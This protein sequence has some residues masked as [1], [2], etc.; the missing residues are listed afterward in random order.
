MT[1][2]ASGRIRPE[3]GYVARYIPAYRMDI[4]RA[5]ARRLENGLVVASGNPPGGTS[6]ESLMVSEEE[7]SGALSRLDVRNTWIRGEWL[8][9][10]EMGPLFGPNGP[11]R[12][13]L[14]EESPR[15]LSLRRL[16]RSA[17][18]RGL[19]TIL[20]G[21]FSS[22]DRPLGSTHW[23]DRRRLATARM[24]DALL[25]YTDPLR[26]QLADLMPEI[27]VF[28][29]RNTLNTDV[30]LPVGDAFMEEGRSAIRARLGLPDVPTLLFLGR[31]IPEKGP[32]R[33]VEVARALAQERGSAVSVVMIG[34]GPERSAVEAMTPHENVHVR[35]LGAMTDLKASAPWIAACD[36]LV[37]PGYLGLSVNH[38]LALG[39]PVVAPAP[40]DGGVG[41]SPEWTYVRDAEN[42]RFAPSN[43]ASD[44]A[45]AA[46]EVLREQ[47]AYQARA[48]RFARRELRLDIMVSGIMAAIGHVAPNVSIQDVEPAA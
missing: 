11:S 41:H 2:D 22:I 30:L 5:A 15:T 18:K 6:M 38:A 48:A 25:T 20:W 16:I 1:H 47:A 44:L 12:V 34:D 29:A 46:Q 37:N 39:V 31:M 28:T 27:P 14:I 7:G 19:K 8:H 36:V 40:T 3:V 4:V 32:A 45:D 33:V 17:R 10:Q 42:G 21:H 26:D 24:A 9:W 43:S 23:R 13:L 35:F